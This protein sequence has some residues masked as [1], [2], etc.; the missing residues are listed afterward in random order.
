MEG[1]SREIKQ[2][3]Q[4]SLLLPVREGKSKKKRYSHNEKSL[5]K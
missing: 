3:S 4:M 1:L 5:L 2:F